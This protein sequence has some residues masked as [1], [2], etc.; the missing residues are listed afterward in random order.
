MW[1]MLGRKE[2]LVVLE[3]EMLLKLGGMLM[4]GPATHLEVQNISVIVLC[5]G[6][7]RMS[8]K[9]YLWLYRP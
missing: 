4:N 5:F 8:H 1:N 2:T 7:S 3:R 9:V 6:T